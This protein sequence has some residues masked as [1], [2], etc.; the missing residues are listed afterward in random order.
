MN[1]ARAFCRWLLRQWLMY[2]AWELAH[3]LRDC[4]RDGLTDSL[5]LR[6]FRGQLAALEVRI[7]LLQPPPRRARPAPGVQA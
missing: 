7:A 5:S 6:E 4:S 2:H 1:P 3:Y